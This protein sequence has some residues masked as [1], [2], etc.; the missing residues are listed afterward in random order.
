MIWMK[1]GFHRVVFCVRKDINDA[2]EKDKE[3]VDI[4]ISELSCM[5]GN[6]LFSDVEI[7][8]K[9]KNK[10]LAHSFML[11]ARC[12][13]LANFLQSSQ[14]YCKDES[15][16]GLV[17]V[18][19]L[20][21][22]VRA[23]R[24]VLTYI[25]TACFVPVLDETLAD[26][27]ELVLRW[28]LN[29]NPEKWKVI[30]DEC[31]KNSEKD[32][33]QCNVGSLDVLLKSLWEGEEDMNGNEETN[34]KIIAESFLDEELAGM[35]IKIYSQCSLE[36]V[37]SCEKKNDK[38]SPGENLRENSLHQKSEKN[39]KAIF[40]TKTSSK[41][42]PLLE[43]EKTSNMSEE[44]IVVNEDAV[45]NRTENFNV[46]DKGS[47][48]ISNQSLSTFVEINDVED[49][50]VSIYSQSPSSFVDMISSPE[51]SPLPENINDFEL[52]D[53]TD[54]LNT[55]I[56]AQD[57]SESD[58]NVVDVKF[59]TDIV[60][61]LV[62]S[63]PKKME[64]VVV[65]AEDQQ[66]ASTPDEREDDI[67][68]L[69]P[70][71]SKKCSRVTGRNKMKQNDSLSNVFDISLDSDDI[72]MSDMKDTLKNKNIYDVSGLFSNSRPT[73]PSLYSEKDEDII[74][75]NNV[76]SN[77]NSD[78][79]KSKSGAL[80]INTKNGKSSAVTDNRAKEIS[81]CHK[82]RLLSH[83]MEE[84]HSYLNDSMGESAGIR[85]C[86]ETINND[87][88]SIDCYD[89][90]GFNCDLNEFV[91]HETNISPREQWKDLKTSAQSS[92]NL[93][94]MS[95]DEDVNIYHEE[96]TT[97]QSSFNLG[98]M[99]TDE[100]VNINHGEKTPLQ[101][102]FILGAMS[103]DQD[104]NIDHGE[105]TPPQNSSILGAMSTDED[106]NI[107]HG[108]KTPSQN[109]F[110]LEAESTDK[111][112]VLKER[113]TLGASKNDFF[114]RHSSKVTG[115]DN[116]RTPCTPMLDYSNMAT[117]DL[118]VELKQYG[119]R[120]LA[121]R[122]MVVKLK[123][124]YNYTHKDK[125]AAESGCLIDRDNTP[126][127]PEKDAF[128][129][130]DKQGEVGAFSQP[131]SNNASDS[132]SNSDNVVSEQDED[133]DESGRLSQQSSSNISKS[134]M[135]IF[136]KDDVLYKKILMY[137]P[138]SVCEVFETIKRNGI[139]CNLEQLK[140][141]LDEQCI[142]Y[143]DPRTNRPQRRKKRGKRNPVSIE[144]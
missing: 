52:D 69:S 133:S 41:G 23:V 14:S 17:R 110:I 24:A 91:M 66:I 6:P 62:S 25:Y 135:S 2:E 105:K 33:D 46:V 57:T 121:K 122:K 140:N 90:G 85:D 120:P 30:K 36:Q 5:V 19:L 64:T 81:C 137:L 126:V 35:T 93:G 113:K 139:Q 27:K 115:E 127:S 20:D 42:S 48:S 77:F 114:V 119:V 60:D 67:Y 51:F 88:Q 37:E 49:G 138:I 10:I 73:S 124:I 3:D 7:I 68:L 132:L 118:K 58:M 84:S 117:P 131:D 55:A 112:A 72:Q 103:T 128:G 109:S 18:E 56:S 70:T 104:V 89:D 136:K 111:E 65:P 79:D 44:Y 59:T 1:H 76:E 143:T 116:L 92:V 80:S 97:P 9:N 78:N 13:T 74:E 100:D 125:V 38:S 31:E 101:N 26:V 32:V 61:D 98:A 130:H 54:V 102:S 83:N 12:K 53:E 40:S 123:E 95:T 28:N 21:I 86:V 144:V 87:D 75:I 96:K 34:D 129:S 71:C 106:V 15:A 82:L 99:S 16:N 94:A 29:I 50:S 4:L 134:L 11:C 142:T 43:K 63:T 108:E 45:K 22:D 47:V 39:D 107:N 141:Y 8:A